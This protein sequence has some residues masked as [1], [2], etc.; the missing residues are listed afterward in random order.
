MH[1]V[2]GALHYGKTE[3]TFFLFKAPG[4][5]FKAAGTLLKAA[6]TLFKAAGAW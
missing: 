3:L 4:A 6:G 5:L 2:P 1:L